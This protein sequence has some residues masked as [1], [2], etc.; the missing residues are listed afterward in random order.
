MRI[1]ELFDAL[2]SVVL[3]LFDGV[4][5]PWEVIGKIGEYIESITEKGLVGYNELFPGVYIGE[6]VNISPLST[7]I[8]P[9]II[10]D[11]TEIRPGAY[12][13]GNII[14]GKSCVIG[15]STEIKN[16][17][18]FDKVAVPH[19]NYVGDS[20]IGN[21]AHL[22]AGVICSNLKSD[23]SLVTVKGNKKYD[24]GLKK[25]G[26]I[27]GDHAEVGCGCV[28]NPGTI[29]GKGSSVYPLSSLRG[30]IPEGHIVKDGKT[31]IPKKIK[32]DGLCI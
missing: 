4:E 1:C 30:V 13:R 20:V 16:S 28:L 23:K 7:I 5:Y 14:I 25:L 31:V 9:V 19:Y 21:F 6:N 27:L 12:L 11:N 24:T 2:P 29:I 8:P 22:G 10:G 26:A 17:I 32:Y 18:L 15:N 3:P